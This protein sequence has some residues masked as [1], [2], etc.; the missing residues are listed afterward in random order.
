[1]DRGRLVVLVVVEVAFVGDDAPMVAEPAEPEEAGG[2]PELMGSYGDCGTRSTMTSSRA[3][4]ST[5]G[6]TSICL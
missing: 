6:R 2:T 1:V 4:K 3:R 5:N